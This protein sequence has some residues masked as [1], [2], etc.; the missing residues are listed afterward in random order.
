MSRV[1]YESCKRV[2]NLEVA[3]RADRMNGGEI[4]ALTV[5]DFVPRPGEAGFPRESQNLCGHGEAPQPGHCRALVD[6]IPRA[7]F[8]SFDCIGIRNDG[9]SRPRRSSAIV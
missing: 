2:P 8:G 4:E 7:A 6:I 9:D 5:G 3:Y 1:R